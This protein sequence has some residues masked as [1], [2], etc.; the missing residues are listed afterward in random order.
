MSGSLREILPRNELRKK[1]R[2]PGAYPTVSRT[3]DRSRKG[4]NNVFFD[5]A[6]TVLFTASSSSLVSM[7]TTLP[8]NSPLLSSD[9]SGN[10]T[11]SKGN[12]DRTATRNWV[13]VGQ[14]VEPYFPFVESKLF[15]QDF[16]KTSQFYLTGSDITD[17]GLGFS[18]PI[19]SKTQIRFTL[20]V[21]ISQKMD[22]ITASAYYFNP[23]RNAFE[24]IGLA[25]KIHTHFT[26]TV[27]NDAML[28]GP[29]GNAMVNLPNNSVINTLVARNSLTAVL[30]IDPAAATSTSPFADLT[31]APTASHIIDLSK[32]IS[33]PFLIEKAV[34]EL[35][36][37]AG[38]GWLQDTT[39]FKRI[40]TTTGDKTDDAGG[41][42][43]TVSLLNS[44]PDR[45]DLILSATIIPAGDNTALTQ[46]TSLTDSLFALGTVKYRSFNGFLGF[47]SP[48]A[49]VQSGSS[50]SFTGSVKMNAM[51]AISAG[52]ISSKPGT[53]FRSDVLFLDSAFNAINPFG[54]ATYPNQ[55]SGRSYFGK[56]YTIPSNLNLL[57][58][59][60]VLNG[61]PVAPVYD[62]PDTFVYSQN[63]NSPY[64]V[65]PTDKLV[66]CVS[67]YRPIGQNG[68]PVRTHD[69]TLASGSINIVL[70]GSL[71]S[72]AAEYHDPLNQRLETSE[73]HEIIGLD[74]VLDKFD[75]EYFQQFSG[76]YVSQQ[77]TGNLMVPNGLTA[78]TPGNRFI[79]A[80]AGNTSSFAQTIEVVEQWTTSGSGYANYS[81]LNTRKKEKFSLIRFSQANSQNERF[82]DS[83]VP[84]MDDVFTI[85][86]SFL[87]GVQ[88]IDNN[89]SSIARGLP[90]VQMNFDTNYRDPD[91]VS[92][93]ETFLPGLLSVTSNV[94]WT[95]SFPYESKYSKLARKIDPAV[96]TYKNILSVLSFPPTAQHTEEARVINALINNTAR[97]N[98]WGESDNYN[99][100][101]GI[102]STFFSYGIRFET[103]VKMCYGTGDL[104][105]YPSATSLSD[106][107]NGCL[108]GPGGMSTPGNLN[109]A[110]GCTQFP[111][112]RAQLLNSGSYSGGSVHGINNA[113]AFAH[114]TCPI[115]RTFRGTVIRGWK[116]GIIN[117]FAQFSKAYFNL[118]H[119]GHPRDLM[120]Q[121]PDSK[122]YESVGFKLDGS[123]GGNIGSLL[124]PVQVKY[125]NRNGEQTK[126][127][128]TF[129]SNLS[130]EATSSLPYFDGV[131]RNR[132]EPL[133]VNILGSTFVT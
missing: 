82:F 102:L 9:M 121:R 46:S 112:F 27:L 30:T 126:P 54:R 45:R 59:M 93:P 108:G 53:D 74:H 67:K 85:D 56:E 105:T 92:N 130:I 96:M 91:I 73:A 113:A 86:G 10:I 52:V 94:D 120:E 3:G 81:D 128:F 48:S 24:E 55:P 106:Y 99:F 119:F 101:S 109:R 25:R 115:N 47:G 123:P 127:E 36:L 88:H 124:G 19:G 83:M 110:F 22:P 90:V 15:E 63:A 132:E 129:S 12:V 117:G 116:Y 75:T 84:T 41:P 78:F 26:G 33:H 40:S 95:K 20:P 14:Q 131:A 17:V 11:V 37:N 60:K 125:I 104:N 29:F 18:T 43:I 1:D 70:Y 16:D 6:N 68:N 44:F 118:R 107:T 122:F 77:L 133:N 66:L 111:N 38:A 28:F 8:V 76:T 42:C 51:A 4:N 64:L 7:P 87:Y 65:Y 23:V 71:I 98:W 97:F 49:T 31:F 35:P 103:I 61:R 57:S 34:I 39:Q 13:S 114:P 79:W 50:G 80:D 69:V 100:N 5:D 32:Y 62:Y 58:Q 21:A 2:L 89:S 72:N